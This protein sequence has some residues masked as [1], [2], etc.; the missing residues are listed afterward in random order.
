MMV[1]ICSPTFSI[2]LLSKPKLLCG[3]SADP[4]HLRCCPVS[5]NRVNRPHLALLALKVKL[6]VFERVKKA[7]VDMVSA[8]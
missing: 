5:P 2:E 4:A 6:D 7:I 8:F 1:M 3:Q